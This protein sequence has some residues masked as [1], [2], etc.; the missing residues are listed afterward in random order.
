[1][2]PAGLLIGVLGVL[3]ISQVFLGGALERLGII[4]PTPGG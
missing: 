4:T 1:V 2:N 3:V